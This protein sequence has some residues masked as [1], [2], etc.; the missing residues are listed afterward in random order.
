MLTFD[1]T[2]STAPANITRTCHCRL[3]RKTLRDRTPARPHCS[4]KHVLNCDAGIED[5]PDD[6]PAGRRSGRATPEDEEPFSDEDDFIDDDLGGGQAGQ[7]RRHKRF[8]G[9][10]RLSNKAMQVCLA[11]RGMLL[12]L[13]VMRRW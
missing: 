2:G 9:G 6:A 7:R 11:A 13:A 12:A 5:L 3:G 4:C 10:S 1:H 8:G